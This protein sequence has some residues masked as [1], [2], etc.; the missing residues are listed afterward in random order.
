MCSGIRYPHLA[1]EDAKH[2]GRSLARRAS[3][4]RSLKVGFPIRRSPDQSLFAAPR[5]LSQRTTSFIASQRQGIHQ[6]PFSHF[7]R[8]HGR[9]SRSIPQSGMGQRRTREAGLPPTPPQSASLIAAQ[10]PTRRASARQA[11]PRS[12]RRPPT[13]G[14][15][16][17]RSK[18]HSNHTRHA[19][20]TT[21]RSN[22][23]EPTPRATPSGTPAHRP[24]RSLSGP[25]I[26]HAFSSR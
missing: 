25:T 10:A 6:M 9:S 2:A 4:L 26:G 18:D 15:A 17:R 11:R 13:L 7:I 12:I 3:Q 8:S 20:Q 24:D 1:T 14:A 21:V 5:G 19:H 16:A 23:V 22:A